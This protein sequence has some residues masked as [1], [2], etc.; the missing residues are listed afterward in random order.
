MNPIAVRGLTVRY[1]R[2]TALADVS[3]DVERGSV[4]VL[5]GRSGA[6][7]STLVQCLSGVKSPSGGTA[8]IFGRNP[9][10]SRAARSRLGLALAGRQEALVL[11]E[12]TAGLD[13]AAARAFLRDVASVRERGTAILL[14][15]AD[16]ADVERIATHVGVLRE[17]RLVLDDAIGTLKARFRRIRY[18]NE[19]TE[20]RAA[21]GTELDE[22]DAV[23]VKV[24]GWGIEAVVSDFEEEKFA[25]FRDC[26]GVVDAAAEAL[27]VEEIL[28]A[29]SGT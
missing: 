1:G 10:W 5:F 2:T 27:S 22:F 23:R 8:R 24:R 11:D 15:T 25:R 14:L 13:P 4:Y 3:L 12:P 17:G 19:M 16:A 21:F 28:A 29:V 7:K 26:E 18:S 6:G 9:R 20:E